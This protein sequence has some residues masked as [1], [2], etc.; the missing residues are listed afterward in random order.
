MKMYFYKLFACM[1]VPFCSFSVS[2]WRSSI[3]TPLHSKYFSGQWEVNPILAT[4]ALSLMHSSLRWRAGGRTDGRT[5]EQILWLHSVS[6]F[7]IQVTT[8]SVVNLKRQILPYGIYHFLRKNITIVNG[9]PKSTK[10]PAWIKRYIFWHL[11]LM[12][13]LLLLLFYDDVMVW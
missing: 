11:L 6:Q 8:F 7:T 10:L 1:V 13:F 4:F 9:L 2:H 12:L 3:P 5:D